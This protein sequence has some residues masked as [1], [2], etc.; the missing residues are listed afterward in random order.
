MMRPVSA[1]VQ[2]CLARPA[3]QL[4]SQPLDHSGLCGL[5]NAFLAPAG[6]VGRVRIR[7]VWKTNHTIRGRHDPLVLWMAT[8]MSLY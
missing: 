8:M 4:R 1:M 3:A 2:S 6:S 7:A 5:F